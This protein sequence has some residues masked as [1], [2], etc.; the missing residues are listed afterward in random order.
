MT[1]TL[2]TF[3]CVELS[4]EMQHKLD[5]MIKQLR[6]ATPERSVRW[7]K[8]EKIHLTLK[9]LGDTRQNDVPQIS[10]ALTQATRDIKK[11]PITL[12]GLGCFPNLKQPRVVWVGINPSPSLMALQRVIEKNISPLGYPTED[13]KFSPHLTLGRVKREAS[14]AEA[15]SVG[16]AV[17]LRASQSFGVESIS[18]L[19]LMKSDLQRSGSIYT[20]LLSV[21]LC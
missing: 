16:E 20:S 15:A 10:E 2:R 18:R 4:S 12:H 3:I 14:S 11:F 17:R 8:A 13:R 5:E 9:F 19:I 1:A 21:D 6:R 7:D